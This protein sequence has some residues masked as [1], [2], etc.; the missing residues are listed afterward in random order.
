WSPEPGGPN[1]TVFASTTE[2]EPAKEAFG[3][4]LIVEDLIR[5]IQTGGQTQCG[6]RDGRWTIEMIMA[7][8]ESHRLNRPVDLPLENRKH[9]LS[10][11]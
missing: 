8:Y 4:R 5:A 2:P 9:P 11:L 6:P 1:W 7:A 10:L 3:N